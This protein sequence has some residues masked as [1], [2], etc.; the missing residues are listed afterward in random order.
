MFQSSQG[1]IRLADV[2]FAAAIAGSRVRAWVRDDIERGPEGRQARA[3]GWGEHIG[4][5]HRQQLIVYLVMSDG[6]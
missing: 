1:I 6:M 5:G 2:Q 4:A 3:L